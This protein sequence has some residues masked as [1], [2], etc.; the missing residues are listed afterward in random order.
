MVDSL[1]VWNDGVGLYESRREGVK[2]SVGVHGG[3]K[4]RW[5]GA[6]GSGAFTI[7]ILGAVRL[8]LW[9]LWG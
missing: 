6:D 8:I 4:D 7:D 5:D 9:G 3:G 2:V 1:E